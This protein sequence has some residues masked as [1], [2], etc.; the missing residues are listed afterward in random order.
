MICQKCGTQNP[1]GSQIC[2]ICRAFME[3]TPQ[4][5]NKVNQLSTPQDG[6]EELLIQGE[7]GDVSLAKNWGVGIVLAITIFIVLVTLVGNIPID[8]PQRIGGLVIGTTTIPLRELLAPFYYVLSVLI[9]VSIL[10]ISKTIFIPKTYIRV[11]EKHITGV[12]ASKIGDMLIKTSE[13]VFSHNEITV[14]LK[15]TQLTIIASGVKYY[16]YAINAYEIQQA[17]FK[18]KRL[19]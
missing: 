8:I 16:V 12:G 5:K 7:G 15:Y 13:F 1:S 17:I 9:A 6:K 4:N 19:G 2:M 10:P 14:E 3:P 11:Y 18:Q